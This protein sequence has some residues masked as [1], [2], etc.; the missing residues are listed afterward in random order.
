[1]ITDNIQSAMAMNLLPR[2]RPVLRKRMVE[3]LAAIDRDSSDFSD[4]PAK[5]IEHRIATAGDHFAGSGARE[6]MHFIYKATKENGRTVAK[7]TPQLTDTRYWSIMFDR[8][9]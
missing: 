5:P 3:A 2:L 6:T 7:R 4:T 9:A 1:M 8:A